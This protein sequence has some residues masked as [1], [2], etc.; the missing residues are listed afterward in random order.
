MR[1]LKQL[2]VLRRTPTVMRAARA[3]Y[4]GV[5]GLDGRMEFFFPEDLLPGYAWAFPVEPG[6][7]NVGVALAPGSRLRNS[8]ASVILRH[9]ESK[10]DGL[11]WLA[12]ARRVGPIQGYPIRTDFPSHRVHG[13][14]WLLIGESAGLV[15]PITGEGIDLAMESGALAAE[16][17]S[18]ALRDDDASGRMLRRYERELRRRYAG[19]FRDARLLQRVIL[20]PWLVNR[21]IRQGRRHRDLAVTIAT[22]ALGVASPWLFATPRVWWRILR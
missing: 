3:Y 2:G 22:V 4:E 15:N 19:Y 1:L 18:A 21:L 14:N 20:R 8:S 6:M 13:A 10:G 7:A 12:S 5:E 16:F 9:L 11:P 17:A